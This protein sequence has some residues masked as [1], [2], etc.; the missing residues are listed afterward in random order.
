[1]TSFG[2]IGPA[3]RG[4]LSLLPALL[5]AVIPF[6][7]AVAQPGRSGGKIQTRQSGENCAEASPTPN[8]RS[9]ARQLVL[10][11]PPL[12]LVDL[13]FFDR[14]ERKPLYL[15]TVRG[16]HYWP[17]KYDLVPVTGVRTQWEPVG[18]FTSADVVKL[19]AS[20]CYRTSVTLNGIN[21]GAFNRPNSA[22]NKFYVGSDRAGFSMSPYFGSDTGNPSTTMRP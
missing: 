17:G 9:G 12:M 4:G 3:A 5:G 15:H 7:T 6:A 8:R 20:D 18:D 19:V 13:V 2:L 1:M 22:S 11:S 10:A 16:S 21:L 14:L